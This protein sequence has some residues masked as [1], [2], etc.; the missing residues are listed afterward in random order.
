MQGV[1]QF[2]WMLCFYT[3]ISNW[4]LVLLSLLKQLKEETPMMLKW[5]WGKTEEVEERRQVLLNGCFWGILWKQKIKLVNRA[6]CLIN[7]IQ[8]K[9]N[10]DV[11]AF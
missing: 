10:S 9:N 6:V 4:S 7:S 8:V 5:L 3:A 1:A 2:S 11:T